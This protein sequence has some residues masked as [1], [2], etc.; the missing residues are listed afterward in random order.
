MSHR[1]NWKVDVPEGRSGAWIVERFT[2]DESG[3]AW[4]FITGK[5][6]GVSPGTYTRLKRDGSFDVTMSDTPDEYRDHL[7]AIRM[8]KGHVLLNGLGLGCVLQCCA[9]KPEV[10]KITVIERSEDVI[11]LVAPHYREKY[12]NK[13]EIIH[14]D[15]M[16]YK[17][18]KGVRYGAVWHDI[19]DNMCED[20]LPQMHTLHRKYG[21]RTDWQGSWGRSL[22]EYRKRQTKDAFWRR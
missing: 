22:I 3:S 16:E 1:D 9:E 20:N 6:R 18:P 4:S 12:G 15:A 14:A 2:V 17:P 11:A 8:A 5:G 19:W 10:T 7:E 21:R 13:I